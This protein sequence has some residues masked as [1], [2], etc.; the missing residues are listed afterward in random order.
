M[1]MSR[2]IAAR[3]P[4]GFSRVSGKFPGMVLIRLSLFLPF[5]WL[6]W[7]WLCRGGA[8]A[9]GWRRLWLSGA[10]AVGL[11]ILGTAL[12]GKFFHQLPLA[13]GLASLAAALGCIVFWKHGLDEPVPS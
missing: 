9:S 13:F 3:I 12:A 8:I 10:L 1:E 11:A 4:I 6:A 2:S 7:R 5:V